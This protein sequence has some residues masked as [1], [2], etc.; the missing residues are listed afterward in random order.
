MIDI[1]RIG[2]GFKV[3]RVD[4]EF[5]HRKIPDD[6]RRAAAMVFMRMSENE[7]IELLYA[8]VV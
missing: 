3:I 7:I 5:F 6:L 1:T 4:N 8:D 2:K